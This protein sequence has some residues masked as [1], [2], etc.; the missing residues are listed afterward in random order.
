[1]IAGL[2][3]QQA[4]IDVGIDKRGLRGDGASIA[5]DGTGDVTSRPQQA[6]QV[7]QC[8]RVI[9]RLRNRLPKSL[10]GRRM[11]PF[12]RDGRGQIVEECRALT[13]SNC[14]LDQINGVLV[15]P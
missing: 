15:P 11:S 8:F 10:F 4:K 14:L 13:D 2:F 1:M 7:E 5:F 3:H 12:G 6:T 9:G